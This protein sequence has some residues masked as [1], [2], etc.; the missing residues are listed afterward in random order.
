MCY[1]SLL[2]VLL[3]IQ[4]VGCEDDSA[5][6]GSC[7]GADKYG[8]SSHILYVACYGMIVGRNQIDQPLNGGVETF[9]SKYHTKT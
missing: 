8:T 4:E 7:Y 2:L 3:T 1:T 9:G 5:Y 6:N